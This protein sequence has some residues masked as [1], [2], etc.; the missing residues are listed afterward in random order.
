MK[1]KYLDCYNNNLISLPEFPPNLDILYCFTNK[2]SSLSKL[3]NSL[4]KL[5]SQNNQLTNLPKLPLF[6]RTIRYDTNYLFIIHSEQ[7]NRFKQL[8][9]LLKYKKIFMKN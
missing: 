5:F 2:L 9:Y 7:L 3:S 6:L 8:F 1:I 4:V